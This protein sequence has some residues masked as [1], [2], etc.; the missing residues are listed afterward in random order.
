MLAVSVAALLSV[1]AETVKVALPALLKSR[2]LGAFT[3]MVPKAWVKA[4]RFNVPP[5]KTNLMLA[6]FNPTPKVNVAPA[7]KVMVPLPLIAPSEWLTR[8]P[9][10]AA[11]VKFPDTP[12][13][14][15]PF[16]LSG[17]L[18]VCVLPLIFNVAPVATVTAVTSPNVL[19]LVAPKVKVPALIAVVP[20]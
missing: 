19:A 4:P 6:L 1:S 5:S 12:K 16:E 10:G 20:V 14:K 2:V 9:V 18:N 11:S 8:A 15:V 3:V 13:F 17:A 7:L